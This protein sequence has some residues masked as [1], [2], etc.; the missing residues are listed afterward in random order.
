MSVSF[1]KSDR[2][3]KKYK[4]V[5]PVKLW[6]RFREDK[7]RSPRIVHFG[8]N[9]YQHFHDKIGK[10]KSLD[11]NDVTR[12]RRYRLRHAGII[13]K[14]QRAIDIKYSPAW[15]SYYYLW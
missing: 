3:H 11:H 7:T 4:A 8:D 2:E 1:T 15:F 13:A 14:G 9:R 6:N 10:Y 5:I 12:R